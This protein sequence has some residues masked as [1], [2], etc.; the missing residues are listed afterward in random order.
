M[1]YY[2][3]MIDVGVFNLFIISSNFSIL[4]S[5]FGMDFLHVRKLSWREDWSEI[6]G[7]YGH[8]YGAV[9][10]ILP[11][12]N[13][14]CINLIVILLFGEIIFIRVKQ[15]FFTQCYRKS[16][17]YIDTSYRDTLLPPLRVN[18]SIQHSLYYCACIFC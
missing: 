15:L 4:C 10:C 13:R 12:V 14:W 7:Q 9:N 2:F 8:G 6:Q 5:L 1:V 18:T 17:K 3:F 11:V 16:S